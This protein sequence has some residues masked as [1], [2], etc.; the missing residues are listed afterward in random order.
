MALVPYK[1]TALK[2]VDSNG[3]NFMAGAVVTILDQDGV[4][5]SVYSDNEST[6]M[7]NSFACD[8]NGEA[9]IWIEAGIYSISVSTG[10]YFTVKIGEIG[11]LP[12][13]S[14]FRFITTSNGPYWLRPPDFDI[15]STGN[16]TYYYSEYGNPAA[17]PIG[18]T[19]I[20]YGSEAVY[21]EGTGDVLYIDGMDFRPI[22]V[23]PEQLDG[24]DWIV[25][26]NIVRLTG[27]LTN[28]VNVTTLTLQ[29]TFG[30]RIFNSETSEYDIY[31][32]TPSEILT[33]ADVGGFVVDIT[34]PS[35][36]AYGTG[37]ETSI[38]ATSDHHYNPPIFTGDP[39]EPGGGTQAR[40]DYVL[41]SIEVV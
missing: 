24:E 18:I 19:E 10:K 13:N 26:D 7:T 39:D 12:N 8:E 40:F 14:L 6:P 38:Y 15:F 20:G 17:H 9:Q 4:R 3:V 5:A 11:S 32:G 28:L 41:T 34:I 16:G 25:A 37:Q 35:I 36:Y 31:L 21:E 1:I 33:E 27:Y 2:R 22:R 29:F 30:V 23:Y